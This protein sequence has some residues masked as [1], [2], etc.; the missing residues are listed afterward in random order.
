MVKLGLSS[1]PAAF[2][3]FILL[4]ASQTQKQEQGIKIQ[5]NAIHGGGRLSNSYY[6]LIENA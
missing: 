5:K 3:D 2:E 4:M 6:D 1:N